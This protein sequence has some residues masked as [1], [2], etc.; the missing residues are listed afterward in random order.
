MKLRKL[1]ELP[2]EWVSHNPEIKKKVFVRK[3]EMGNITQV[4]LVTFLPG[5]TADGHTHQ[6]MFE[7]FLIQKGEGEINVDD[8]IIK[9]GAGDCVVISPGEMHEVKN[10]GGEAMEVLVIGASDG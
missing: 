7:T 1:N 2:I 6:D 3:G 10:T 9:V 8:K 5:Q 4:A